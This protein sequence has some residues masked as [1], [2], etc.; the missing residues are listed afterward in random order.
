MLQVEECLGEGHV[1]EHQVKAYEE[2][3]SYCEAIRNKPAE[4]KGKYRRDVKIER[5][6]EKQEKRRK[7]M[8]LGRIV[9]GETQEK[10]CCPD[11]GSSRVAPKE[12]RPGRSFKDAGGKERQTDAE[13]MYCLNP[14]CST[15]TFTIL[16]LTLERWARVSK[17]V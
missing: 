7:Q 14:E 16:P 10:L 8:R 11:C 6:Y 15:K 17:A 13:R 9:E 2:I 5:V 12:V 1:G 4:K 3:K